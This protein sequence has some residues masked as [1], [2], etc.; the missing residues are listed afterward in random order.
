MLR[1]FDKEIHDLISGVHVVPSIP[2]PSH[3]GFPLISPV[4]GLNKKF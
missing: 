3:T 4:L 2:L 1:S